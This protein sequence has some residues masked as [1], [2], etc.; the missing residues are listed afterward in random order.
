MV[1]FAELLEKFGIPEEW[2]KFSGTK[3]YTESCNFEG[4]DKIKVPNTKDIA[5]EGIGSIDELKQTILSVRLEIMLG[6]WTGAVDDVVQVMSVPVFL[7]AE[8]VKGMK[9]AKE[10]GEEQEEKEREEKENRV[11]QDP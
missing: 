9:A 8:A 2:I 11:T 7:L 4:R 10:A 1:F 3:D 6:T 5:K